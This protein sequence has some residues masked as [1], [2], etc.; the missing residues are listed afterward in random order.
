MVMG[1][2]TQ[3]TDELDAILTVGM[4]FVDKLIVATPA[5][6][7]SEAVTV[8]KV[9]TV[10]VTINEP[11][12]LVKLR[13]FNVKLVAAAAILMVAGEPEHTN[14]GLAISITGK[15]ATVIVRAA[16]LVPH[17]FCPL[18]IYVVVV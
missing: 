13:G 6:V 4:G 15:G 11:V 2:P 10:G 5:Q 12:W 1:A 8:Y 14:V 18:T 7:P 16:V 9:F 17:P 3:D